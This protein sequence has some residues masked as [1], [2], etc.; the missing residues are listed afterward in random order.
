MLGNA[1]P[2]DRA[3]ERV[4]AERQ[5]IAALRA[6][7]V[8]EHVYPSDRFE[9]RGVIVCAGGSRMLTCAWVCVSLLRRTLG[10]E[11]PIDVWHLGDQELG[12][13]EAGLLNDL[14]IETV[15]ALEVRKRHPVRVLGGWELK[16]YALVHSRFQE[17]LLLDA[18]NVPVRDP[19]FLFES[20]QYR[21]TGALFWPDVVQ[22]GAESPVWDMCELPYRS[23]RPGSQA[24]SCSTSPGAGRR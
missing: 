18:D 8:A 11:L 10:C 19:S 12:P 6:A 1:E 9:G 13:I 17:V 23:S 15:D 22:L 5:A 2:R 3:S 14:D 21:D 20:P 16:A 7:R 24:R 4:S